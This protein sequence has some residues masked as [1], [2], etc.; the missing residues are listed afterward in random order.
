[1]NRLSLIVRNKIDPALLVISENIYLSAVRN[2]LVS[3]TP[4]TIIGGVFV[5]ISFFPVPGW[6]KLIAPLLPVLKIP[7][8]ATFGLLSVF[9][10]FGIS[11]ELA[12]KLGVNGLSAAL[13]SVLLFL[14]I[15]LS[16]DSHTGEPE[17]SIGCLGASGLFTA[18]M[19]AVVSVRV[20]KFFYDRNFVIRM[21]ESV[22]AAV[23]ESFQALVPLVFL[24]AA[25]W[26]LR[27]LLG[28][29]INTCVQKMF[30]P[31][32]AA[33]DSLPG[34]LLYAFV[35][36]LLWSVGINGDNAMDAIVAPVFLQY[37]AAN[38]EALA[39]GQPLPY[40]TALGFFSVFANVGGTGATIALSLILLNSRNTVYRKVSRLG[41][42]T[43]FF[44]INEPVFFGLPII[45]N[46]VFMIPYILSSLT[47][48]A[49]TYLLMIWGIIGKPCVNIPWT[50]PPIISHYLVTG[51]DWRA[52]VWGV[53]SIATAMLIYYPFARFAERKAPEQGAGEGGQA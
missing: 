29:D 33:L 46:P 7:V 41:L 42:S 51:G 27:F 25:F 43:Q 9:V 50:T 21:P 1:M 18:I 31:L 38:T 39:K 17:L 49:V 13:T 4:L 36:T 10:C 12:S 16:L 19:V 30:Q 28:V 44:Q 32:I 11:H 35:V 34:I 52:C 48:T 20:Q 8:S 2:G 26:T 53:I 24:I 37:L 47:L 14:M 5:I 15:H 3:V 23:Y 40:T 6:N 45:M 22:P